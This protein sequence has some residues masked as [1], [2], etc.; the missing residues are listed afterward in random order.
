MKPDQRRATLRFDQ[1]DDVG[2]DGADDLG[3]HARRDFVDGFDLQIDEADPVAAAVRD[4]LQS[5]GLRPFHQMAAVLA[6]RMANW[7]PSSA[8]SMPSAF[9][10]SMILFLS[11]A[12]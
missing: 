8:L 2:V 11:A 9:I 4:D 1:A 10:K 7:P 5:A 12:L 6:Q 3:G